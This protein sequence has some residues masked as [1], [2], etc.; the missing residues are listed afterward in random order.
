MK[1]NLLFLFFVIFFCSVISFGQEKPLWVAS[2]ENKLKKTEANWK[3]GEKFEGISKNGH[4]NYY[5]PLTS[6]TERVSIK[7]LKLADIP[8]PGKTPPEE[9][10]K[11]VFNEGVTLIENNLNKIAE[12]TL[13]EDFGDEGY[14]WTNLNEDV[15]TT[16]IKFRKRDIFITIYSTSEKTARKFAEYVFEEMP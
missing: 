3:M 10:F 14:I 7:I 9:K 16:L 1:K 2:F 5:F 8:N 11:K 12:K 13:L 6:G 15:L 4:Y